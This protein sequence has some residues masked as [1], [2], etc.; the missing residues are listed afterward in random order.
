MYLITFLLKR[1]IFLTVL[2]L[3]W[4]LKPDPLRIMDHPIP[5]TGA[6]PSKRGM[7]KC[8]ELSS[9]TPL[10]PS[11]FPE[12]G[13]L[14]NA[15][16]LEPSLKD[17]SQEVPSSPKIRSWEEISRE[18]ATCVSDELCRGSWWGG[19]GWWAD[20]WRNRESAPWARANIWVSAIT[21]N[22]DARLQ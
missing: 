19:L 1:L 10:P 2:S 9:V 22:I 4:G 7:P 8:T 16:G 13:M 15:A 3:C 6:S 11:P 21:K 12:Q 20:T 18:Y 14:L 5:M 17:L